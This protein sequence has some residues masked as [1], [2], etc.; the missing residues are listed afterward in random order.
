MGRV[1]ITFLVG[2]PLHRSPVL[3]DIAAELEVKGFDVA[4][5]VPEPESL[6]PAGRFDSELFVL[7]G[8]ADD[9]L[10][11]LDRLE[12]NCVN[13]PAAMLAVHDRWRVVELLRA[14]GIPVPATER[15]PS[16]DH[17]IANRQDRFVKAV[18]GTAGRGAGVILPEESL[19]LSEPFDGPYL[20]Q[21]DVGG[22]GWEAKLYVFG[23]EVRGVR[24]PAHRR[25]G[26]QS[27]P[28]S[29]DHALIA[30]D[31]ARAVG[32][33]LCGV[34]LVIGETGAYVIDI[35]AFPSAA[36]LP[37][38]VTVISTFLQNQALGA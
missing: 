16:Y 29:D 38:A 31:T 24:R 12:L 14:A 34:D 26:G 36:K 10:R 35:N 6:I 33:K 8:L 28:V 1:R 11:G 4:A 9:V 15:V 37:E 3:P 30:Q 7:R 22:T 5:H 20:L 2:K 23:D 32:L 17:V 25:S 13:S 21:E 19:P 27:F 18:D